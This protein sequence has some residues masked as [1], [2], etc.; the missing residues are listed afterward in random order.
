MF[1]K[2]DFPINIHIHRGKNNEI[3]E[4]LHFLVHTMSKAS[5]AVKLKLKQ[6]ACL[7]VINLNQLQMM[8]K[9]ERAQVLSPQSQNFSLD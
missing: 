8:S 3:R 4:V 7:H 6:E 2:A 5:V 9:L 1:F